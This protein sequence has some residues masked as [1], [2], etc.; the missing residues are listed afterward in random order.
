MAIAATVA[1]NGQT[2]VD[3]HEHFYGHGYHTPPNWYASDCTHPSTLGHD[4]LRR[5]FYYHVT[6]AVLP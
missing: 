4:E 6:G 3:M 5:L 2:S 1:D